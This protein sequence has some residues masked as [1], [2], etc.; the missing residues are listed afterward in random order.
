M[1]TRLSAFYFQEGKMAKFRET[2]LML[3]VLLVALILGA[4]QYVG[5]AAPAE[6][7]PVEI[8]EA[9]EAAYNAQDIDAIMACYGEDPIWINSGGAWNGA[10]KIKLLYEFEFSEKRTVDHTNFQVEGDTVVYDCE[11]FD[12]N[13]DKYLMEQYEAVIENGKIKTN[14]L[15]KN[16][17]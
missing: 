8:L 1:G 2:F 13:G 6:P 12:R 3:P 7:S 4:C 10:H 14:F 17:D 16:R 11:Y 15:V 5:P 9:L